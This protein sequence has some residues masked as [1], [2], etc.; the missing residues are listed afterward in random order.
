MKTSWLVAAAL[1]VLILLQ[2]AL[3][4]FAAHYGIASAFQSAAELASVM[5][6][7]FTAGG[8]IVALVSLYT[9]S[10]VDKVVQDGVK[11][12]VQ[13]I[14]QRLDERI[15]TFLDA[16][17][18]F[19]EAQDLWTQQRF[20]SLADIEELVL[21]AEEIEPTLRNLRRWSGTVFFQAARGSYL[22]KH[23]PDSTYSDCPSSMERPALAVKSL[24]RLE[25]EFNAAREDSRLT[26]GLYIAQLH[27]LLGESPKTVAHWI[28]RARAYGTVPPHLD[29]INAL[30]LAAGSRSEHDVQLILRAF[31][32]DIMTASDIAAVLEENCDK[33]V[34]AFAVVVKSV[35]QHAPENP[36]IVT[37]HSVDK[38]NSAFIGWHASA[39]PQVRGGIPEFPDIVVATGAQDTPSFIPLDDL[40]REAT[41]RFTFIAPY[42]F[43][44]FLLD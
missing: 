27:A 30:T 17:T 11:G 26:I 39:L 34:Q 8:L 42:N 20:Q 15:R 32:T 38:W 19:R 33:A 10:N 3:L 36:T 4:L 28:E 31:G 43:E 21:R 23:V 41:E 1:A 37:F 18:S 13:A 16:Y 5:G 14:P 25:P 35:V 44:R 24:R 6:A 7:I 2:P 40:L 29:G 22:R 12:A 9:L